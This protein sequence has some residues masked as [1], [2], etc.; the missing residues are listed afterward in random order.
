MYTKHDLIRDIK[1]LGIAREDTLLVH[2][3]MKAIGEVEGGADAVLDAFIEYMEPGLLVFPTHTWSTIGSERLLFDP[4]TEP[5][6][7][8]I[9]TN[10]FMKRP[11]VV[12][13]LHPTHS[14]AALGRDA[15]QYAAGEEYSDTPCSRSGCWGKLYDRNAKVLFLGCSMKKNTIIHGVEEWNNIENRLTNTHVMM[16]IAMPDGTVMD[17]PMRGHSAPVPDIS[18]NYDKLKAPLVH[19]GIARCGRIGD[20]DSVLC[21]VRKMVDLTS[22]FLK[23]D[24][25][26]FL[27]DS[28]VPE[29]WYK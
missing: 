15:A 4:R 16:Q 3:S 12:R 22:E 1:N 11:G 5:S 2:S 6:C 23:R 18:S 10:L 27:D 19:L 9:L 26:L 29:E 20:A 24:P 28:P 14:I 25:D 7:V 8:G 13:S 21:D 17:R